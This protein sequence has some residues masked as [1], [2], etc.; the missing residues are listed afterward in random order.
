MRR[1]LSLVCSD[2]VRQ[3]LLF[4]GF[5]SKKRSLVGFKSPVAFLIQ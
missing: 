2:F 4:L 1:C 3:R 5:E